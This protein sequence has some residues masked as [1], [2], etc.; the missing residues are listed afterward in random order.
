MD[1][2]VRGPSTARSQRPAA[3]WSRRS[4]PAR[5]ARRQGHGRGDQTAARS[6]PSRSTVEPPHKPSGNLHSLGGDAQRDDVGVVLQDDPVEHQHRQAHTSALR[7]RPA[8]HSGSANVSLNARS[9]ATPPAC[10]FFTAAPPVS[11]GLTSQSPRSQRDRT[12][13]EDHHS[14]VL[15]QAGVRPA[16]EVVHGLT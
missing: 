8:T 9:D 1:R 2:G 5:P 4:R 12:R 14:K 10:T 7:A 6:R 16:L 13:R 3:R 15:R 11:N